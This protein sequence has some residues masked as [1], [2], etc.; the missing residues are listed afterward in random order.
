MAFFVEA[1]D[2]A[3]PQAVV[4]EGAALGEGDGVAVL[5]GD[6]EWGDLG[7]CPT[8]R[9]GPLIRHQIASDGSQDRGIRQ[10]G[11]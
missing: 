7:F 1:A 4:E 2:F 6:G 11:G 10:F 8:G 5:E 9:L 3:D